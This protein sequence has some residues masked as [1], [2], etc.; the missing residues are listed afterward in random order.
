[1]ALFVNNTNTIGVIYTAFNNNVTGSEFITLFLAL[2]MVILF[3][4]L[5]RVP[6]EVTAVFIIPMVIIY[7]AYTAS[8]QPIIVV[9]MVYLGFLTAKYFFV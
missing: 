3:F 1:M 6:F 7:S 4:M 9:L 8:F 2:F 5:F